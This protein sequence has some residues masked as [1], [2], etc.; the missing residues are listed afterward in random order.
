LLAHGEIESLKAFEAAAS[1]FG[2]RIIPENLLPTSTIPRKPLLAEPPSVPTC[3]MNVYHFKDGIPAFKLFF[4][5]NLVSSGGSA[6]RL[7]EQGGA[8]VNGKRIDKYDHLIFEDDINNKEIF[9]R[10]GKKRF[11]RIKVIE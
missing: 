8:Y 11:I 2:R 4:M 6:R 10:A 7:I 9:L 3:E 1:M 5:A